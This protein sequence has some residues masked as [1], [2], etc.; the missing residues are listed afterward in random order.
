MINQHMQKYL[1]AMSG[2]DKREVKEVTEEEML[3]L[4]MEDGQKQADAEFQLRMM[5]GL[6]SQI[7]LNNV[8]YK[9]KQ[10]Q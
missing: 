3:N 7:V 6:G 5:K 2:L 8:S 4:L 9:L 10:V 1:N